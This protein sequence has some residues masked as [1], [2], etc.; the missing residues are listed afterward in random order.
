MSNT[1]VERINIENATINTLFGVLSKEYGYSYEKWLDEILA[2]QDKWEKQ[3]YVEIYQTQQDR[4]WGRA[5]DSAQVPGSSPYYIG[6]FHA[7]LLSTMENDPL[8]IVKF[9]ETKSGKIVDMKL[10]IDHNNFF[11]TKNQKYN[12]EQLRTL[13][14]KLDKFVQQADTTLV[15]E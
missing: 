12:P 11:G 1:Q 6:L 4:S 10:M 5:K 14:I 13:R 8:V 7:R 15:Q 3:G 2:L 9:H